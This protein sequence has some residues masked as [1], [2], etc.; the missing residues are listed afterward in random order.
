MIERKCED[1]FKVWYSAN[2]H[3]C[4]AASYFAAEHIYASHGSLDIREL[5]AINV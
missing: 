4:D 1:D 2:Y 5:V 3:E